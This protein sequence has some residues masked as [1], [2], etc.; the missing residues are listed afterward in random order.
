[1]RKVAAL[2]LLF[3]MAVLL[4]GCAEKTIPNQNT[5]APVEITVFAAASLQD[6]AQELK[7]AYED[8][9]KEVK[10]TYHF[11]G[12]G[13]LQKQI[14]QGAP[15]DLFVSAGKSQMDALEKQNLIVKDSRLDL[16]GNKLVLIAPADSALKDFN[17]LLESTVKKIAVGEPETVPAGKYARETLTSLKIWD[18]VESKI[19]YTKDVRTVL[20]YVENGDAEAGLVYRSDLTG[21]DKAKLILEA[22]QDTHQ[23]IVYPAALVTASQQQQAAKDFL[24]YLQSTE[25]SQIFN[26]YGFDSISK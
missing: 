14:E 7:T 15:A 8:Q 21:S 17:G 4:G 11:A 23:P 13:T 2:C 24:L 26:K 18:K 25:S 19:V 1:M 22:P 6:A 3:I 12:S 20:T 9:H 10:I 5:V 16:L